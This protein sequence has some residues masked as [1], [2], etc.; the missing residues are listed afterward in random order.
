[1]TPQTLS[2][3]P[4]PASAGFEIKDGVSA[5][6]KQPQLHER[7]L[8]SPSHLTP[9]RVPSDLCALAPRPLPPANPGRKPLTSDRT[10]QDWR[11]S[12]H[13]QKGCHPAPTSLARGLA[14][15]RM[16]SLLMTFSSSCPITH[17]PPW[18][19]LWGTSGLPSQ[20]QTQVWIPYSC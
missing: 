14:Q 4:S 19:R 11:G 12:L 1:M 5:L 7:S 17:G 8:R 3:S 18:D 16:T 9:C 15:G 13:P 6:P 20:C 10:G 2:S